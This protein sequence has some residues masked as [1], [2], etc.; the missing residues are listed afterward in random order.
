MILS[1]VGL[2]V[3]EAHYAMYGYNL[4]WSYID[5]PPLVG[6]IHRFLIF[7]SCEGE[8]WVR[9]PAVILMLI[10][11]I[12]LDTFLKNAGFSHKACFW[13]VV[14]INSSFI[15]SLLS[16][17]FIPENLLFLLIFPL[18]SVLLNLEI[19]GRKKDYILLGIILGLMGLSKY[20]SALL[21]PSI[22][23]YFFIQKKMEI[24]FNLKI[25][26][27]L[28]V[29]IF[30]IF[31][32]LM[33]NYYY[34]WESFSYQFH[35]SLSFKDVVWK[36]L[37]ASLA[38]QVGAYNPI[39]FILACYGF[40]KSCTFE[41]KFIRLSICLCI[42][43]FFSFIISSFSRLA[44]P[45]WNALVYLLFIPIG[46]AILYDSGWK[47]MI[48][49]LVVGSSVIV[50]LLHIEIAGKFVKFPDYMSP[51]RDLYQC[52]TV[53]KEACDY[54]KKSQNP[55][56]AIAVANW[57]LASR[58]MYYAKDEDVK[59]FCLDPYNSQFAFWQKDLWD[60][61]DLV[62]VSS[63]ALED[64]LE[65][66][67]FDDKIF[68]GKKDLVLNDGIVDTFYFSLLKNCKSISNCTIHK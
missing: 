31:P 35:H 59:V 50:F 30:L 49:T 4:D 34:N 61:S 27:T 22:F 42:P 38:S 25:I 64:H 23:I 33:W 26:L 39:Y 29:A 17:A 28:S 65:N 62:L 67:I 7:L 3:D 58:L 12:A 47:K 24:I 51:F 45:H 54:L 18:I 46:V 68:L 43:I 10:T 44:L 13:A 19:F 32:V 57:T 9:F 55:Q 60:D 5:H 40:F 21:I 66:V 11:L 37:L 6:W 2:G 15:F 20:T 56:K 36:S 41:N 1:R 14:A 52:D 53:V 63:K 8:F 48:T 16:M